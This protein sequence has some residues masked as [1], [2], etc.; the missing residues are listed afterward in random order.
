AA[1][2]VTK[3]ASISLADLARKRTYY[4]FLAANLR[5]SQTHANDSSV[6]PETLNFSH[7][8]Q[9]T[10]VARMLELF[11]VG[12]D[13]NARRE[14]YALNQ[15]LQA[16]QQVELAYLLASI[17]ESA[18]AIRSANSND[19][20]D[21]LDLR[22]PMLFLNDFRRASHESGVALPFLMS[23]ARQESAFD[24]SARSSADARG[25][26]Q[27]LPATARIAATRA[28][29]PAPTT[30]SLYDPGVNIRLG[31]AH[32]AWLLDRYNQHMWLAAAAYNAGENRVDRWI[33][34]AAGMPTDVWIESIPYY[35]T[36]NYVKNVIAFNQVYGHRLQALHPVFQA[37]ED[38]IQ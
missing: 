17:G 31:A 20:L 22:F 7:L 3:Q 37:H 25:L 19:L 27:M 13:L 1:P 28:G 5:G 16:D 9:N 38:T 15:S 11:A 32:L 24:L 4:G 8:R 36:R 33:K 23:I 6:R 12:D 21:H 2:E 34:D 29:L 30:I 26:M 14:M 18:L 10:G 35:E